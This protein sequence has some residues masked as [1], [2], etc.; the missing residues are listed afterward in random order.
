[1]T[2]YVAYLEAQRKMIEQF[3]TRATRMAADTGTE[4]APPVAGTPLRHSLAEALR[5][6]ASR[7]DPVGA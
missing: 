1:M 5:A 3:E 7:L 6:V 4:A 2:D